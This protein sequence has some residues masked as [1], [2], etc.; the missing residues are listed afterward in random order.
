MLDSNEAAGFDEAIHQ[1][2]ELR[3]AYRDMN[4]LC[5]AVAAASIAPLQPRA[6]QLEQL[7]ARLGLQASKSVNWLGISGWAAAAAA[8]AFM[9]LVDRKPL[10]STESVKSTA[11]HHANKRDILM[12]QKATVQELAAQPSSD[13][14]SEPSE[15]AT[16]NRDAATHENN[17]KLVTK[18]ETKRLVQEIAVLRDKLESVEKREQQR[19]EPVQGMAWPIVIKMRPPNATTQIVA[20]EVATTDAE[21]SVVD[22]LGDALAGKSSLA[23]NRAE[24]GVVDTPSAVPIYDP[25]TGTGT[26]VVNNLS[27]T[28]FWVTAKGESEARLLGKIPPSSEAYESVGFELPA[29]TIPGNFMITND[30]AGKDAPPSDKNTI[31]IGPR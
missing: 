13:V 1:D 4:V 23:D 7:Q 25:A 14:G 16:A 28:N 8:F 20:T 9:L 27:N 3:D 24:Q 12:I 22:V 17:V 31:L 11:T 5:A 15:D 6:G 26:L 30:S 18:M 2:P 29:G 19:L 10:V 21:T